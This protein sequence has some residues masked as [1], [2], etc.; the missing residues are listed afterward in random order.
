MTLLFIRIFFLGIIVF[1]GY[2]IGS[3]YQMEKMAVG[4]SALAGLVLIGIETTMKRVSVRGL[5]SMVFGLLLGVFMAKLVSDVISLLPLSEEML[6]VT[7]VVLT[8]IFSYLGAV[9]ALRGKDE[10][11]VII[12]Y[13][14][15]KRQD[16]GER[17]SILDTSAIIDGRIIEV[18]RT[19]FFDDRLLIPR[20]VLAELQA[21]ADS[22]DDLKR[23]R[24]RRGLEI[25][26]KL[27]KEGIVD[28]HEEDIPSETGVDA[29]LIR[30]ARM[31]DARICTTDYSLTRVAKIQEVGA[32]NVH[33]LANAVR[34]H[35]AAGDRVTLGLVKEG[36]E[37]GQ[38]LAYMPDGTMVVVAEA[39]DR[40]GQTAEIEITS[41]LQ[42]QG[43]EMLFG[44]LV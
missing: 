27:K 17:I 20:F 9:M 30:L 10:F 24:G 39:K 40:I 1:V 29:K 21:L 36:K 28:I 3:L 15:F 33:E 18:Y 43:G 31:I 8:M 42:T 32:L 11:H 44:K 16:V 37:P 26:G 34:L 2:F 19:Q 5:S 14:R 6:S 38:A 22:D 35:L 25:V 41:V 13:V 7:R 12:P 23:Q 4:V